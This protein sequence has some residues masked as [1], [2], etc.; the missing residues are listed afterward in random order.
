MTKLCEVDSSLAVTPRQRAMK[1]AAWTEGALASMAGIGSVM[2]E[3]IA[4]PHALPQ[5]NSRKND[6]IPAWNG[7]FQ[8]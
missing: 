7:H 1:A 8:L 2:R 3:I 6:H 5:Q 4:A